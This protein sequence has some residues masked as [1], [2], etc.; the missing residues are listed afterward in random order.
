MTAILEFHQNFAIY[1]SM[2]NSIFFSD[3][4]YVRSK[5]FQD[6]NDH[7]KK[8]EGEEGPL[9]PIKEY[10]KTSMHESVKVFEAF[11][12]KLAKHSRPSNEL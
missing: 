1:L 5:L 11:V 8:H 7:D 2:K 3:L 4:I 6:L 9:V 12:K 10:K